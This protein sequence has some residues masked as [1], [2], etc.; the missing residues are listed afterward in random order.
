[1]SDDSSGSV[2]APLVE[3][4][5]RSALLRSLPEQDL[6][7]VLGV[8]RVLRRERGQMLLRSGGDAVLVVLSGTAK[9][10]RAVSQ[11]EEVVLGLLGPGDAAGLTGALGT[12]RDGDVTALTPTTALLL[13]GGD[14]RSMAR[15]RPAV[16]NAWLQAATDELSDLRAQVLAFS[17]TSTTDRV[18]YRLVELAE[19]FGE[20]IDGEVRIRAQL[21][22][23]ELASWARA[24]RE[25][26][27]KALHELRRARILMTRRRSL[28]ILDLEALRDRQPGVDA[29]AVSE[30]QLSARVDAGFPEILDIDL[31]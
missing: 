9:E 29:H 7:A 19:R 10:H 2:D 31:R 25:S 3:G 4:V 18:V 6:T 24:S 28:T 5:H 21:T 1:M 8:G 23:E 14:L 30:P 20:P 26:V 17:A 12:P 16:A 15:A 11:V 13:P 22:Q 27:A